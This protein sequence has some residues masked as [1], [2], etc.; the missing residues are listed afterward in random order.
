MKTILW[1]ALTANGNYA[2]SSP[3]HPPKQKAPGDFAA[4]AKKAGNFIVGR[5]TFLGFKVSGAD[6]AFG[7]ADIVVL[8]R[9][10]T[11]VPGATCAV[12]PK[13]AL[14]YLERNGHKTALLA[15]GESLH[16]AFLAEDLVD[17]LVFNVTPALESKGLKLLLPEGKYKEVRLL[18]FKDIGNGIVQLHYAVDH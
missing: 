16:N 17:E 15:G 9:N 1:A 2:Q 8:S 5:R 4:H 11:E 14:S 18:E 6:K 3:E 10:A 12:S 13:E 7:E